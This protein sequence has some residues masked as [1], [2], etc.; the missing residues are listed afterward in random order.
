MGFTAWLNELF[1]AAERAPRR[2]HAS[3]RLNARPRRLVPLA[4]ILPVALAALALFGFLA[5]RQA[6]VVEHRIRCFH[7]LEMYEGDVALQAIRLLEG[8]LLYP[9]RN[10][11][12][13]PL[14]Y[15][16]LYSYLTALSMHLIDVEKLPD[17]T[18]VARPYSLY[19]GR[20]VSVLMTWVCVLTIAGWVLRETRSWFAALCGACAFVSINPLVGT[21]F[22]L[23]RVDMT[24][25]AMMGVGSWLLL[26][27]RSP[28]EFSEA[29]K[30]LVGGFFFVMAFFTKQS[31]G[32]TA[33]VFTMMAALI[34]PYRALWS[35]VA[36]IGFGVAGQF[37]LNW[38]NVDF[39]YLTVTVPSKHP[40]MIGDWLPQLVKELWAPAGIPLAI[41]AGWWVLMVERR[42]WHLVLAAP[43]LLWVIKMYLRGLMVMGGYVNHYLPIWFFICVYFG[44]ALG[45]FVP[46]GVMRLRS[47]G[48]RLALWVLPF[49]FA[50]GIV[51]AAR[52][53]VENRPLG[54][55]YADM[56]TLPSSVREGR[57]HPAWSSLPPSVRAEQESQAVD[58][59]IHW[60][61][62]AGVLGVVLAVGF[63]ASAQG[64]CSGIARHKPSRLAFSPV[65]LG[66]VSAV[67]FSHFTSAVTMDQVRAK[68]TVAMDS[69]RTKDR[70]RAASGMPAEV[71][72]PGGDANVEPAPAPPLEGTSVFLRA[73]PQ[74]VRDVASLF[75]FDANHRP[76]LEGRLPTDPEKSR[77]F[78]QAIRELDGPVWIPHAGYYAYLAG[79]GSDISSDHVRDLYVGGQPVPPY[80]LEALNRKK[81]KYI[82]LN[83]NNIA[84]DWQAGPVY[85]AIDRNYVH[86][87]NWDELYGARALASVDRTG[88]K[89]R[90][91]L[92]RRDMAD[93]FREKR[94]NR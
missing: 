63:S 17:G 20:V 87:E 59:M 58:A 25:L 50:A 48:P 45:T 46:S 26:D 62:C 70:E 69:V 71:P 28:N 76:V 34:S 85:E 94:A 27:R 40:K 55:H 39:W 49:L 79:K 4:A 65:A 19:A 86:V 57:R 88:Q 9:D 73:F 22:D 37:Y 42:R 35:A 38:E 12:Y 41:I 32:P 16:P 23:V 72:S 8:K 43:A 93:D 89:P 90:A 10:S 3:L 68:I 7:D 30:G 92:I 33:I 44:I 77:R 66:L 36:G 82:L 18:S 47:I 51:A 31:A 60:A 11:D 13:I 15:T 53:P 74:V 81:W 64:A 75:D 84:H 1:D 5:F 29:A 2:L 61:I 91:L 80:V 54:L 52:T 67:S 24:F 78:I 6:W 14:L 83:N 56:L 21:W